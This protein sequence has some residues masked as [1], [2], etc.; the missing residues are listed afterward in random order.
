[1]RP[2]LEELGDTKQHYYMPI[3][4]FRI[5]NCKTCLMCDYCPDRPRSYF[6]CI[7]CCIVDAPVIHA[8]CNGYD[9]RKNHESS[10]KTKRRKDEGNQDEYKNPYALSYGSREIENITFAS[11][12]RFFRKSTDYSNEEELKTIQKIFEVF[13]FDFKD[14]RKIQVTNICC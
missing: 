9:C 12:I 14:K 7:I 4:R 13:I 8:V 11:W 10:R 2:C 1:M 5:A 3:D 6:V